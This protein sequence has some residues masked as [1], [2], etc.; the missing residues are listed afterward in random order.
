M[1]TDVCIVDDSV[2]FKCSIFDIIVEICGVHY[3]VDYEQSSELGIDDHSLSCSCFFGAPT[4]QMGK[5][6]E[7][8]F[9][10]TRPCNWRGQ[11]V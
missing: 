5:L 8:L 6:K 7:L 2:M 4:R 3:Y 10:H 1:Q 9:A 11:R